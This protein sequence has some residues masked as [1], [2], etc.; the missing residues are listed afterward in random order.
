[1]LAP[2]AVQLGSRV[3]GDVKLGM[4]TPE[5]ESQIAVLRSERIVINVVEKLGLQNDPEFAGREG[6]FGAERSTHEKTRAVILALLSKL[7][8]TRIGLSY[9]V[10][11]SFSSNDPDKAARIANG[12]AEGYLND[13]IAVRA[14]AARQG[15]EWLETRID[16]L[17]D[18]MNRAALAVQA[19]RAKRDYRIDR[20]EGSTTEPALPM[21]DAPPKAPNHNT[22]EELDSTAKT[23]RQLYESWLQAYTETVQRQTFSGSSAR[24]ISAATRPVS[25]SQPRTILMLVLGLLLGF[26]GGMASAFAWQVADPAVLSC[27]QVRETGLRCLAML[28][29]PGGAEP[30]GSILRRSNAREY[31]SPGRLRRVILTCLRSLNPAASRLRWPHDLDLARNDPHSRL[32]KSIRTVRNAIGA[33]SKDGRVRSLGITSLHP[34]E[35][36]S[37]LVGNLAILHARSGGTALIIDADADNPLLSGT[38]GPRGESLLEVLA[39]TANLESSVSPFRVDGRTV[40]GVDLLTVCP[41]NAHSSGG[42]SVFASEAVRPAIKNLISTYEL[43]IV[44]LPARKPHADELAIGSILDE[45]IVVAARY[46]TPLTMLVDVARKLQPLSASPPAVVLTE[47]PW[48]PLPTIKVH[49]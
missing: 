1:M 9:A 25:K 4:D 14:A 18:Q 13:Q 2:D 19:F 38:Q 16:Q 20:R 5:I 34:N 7:S 26:S 21:A 37:L 31:L 22:L 47:S 39:G 49:K 35:G 45:V 17:R 48:Q 23:Y 42:S 46:D 44:D 11:I 30:L 33:F 32:S 15:S 28:P 41:S 43:V 10:A 36:K 40:P 6:W 27:R 24:V 3:V 12:F 29:N 8:V